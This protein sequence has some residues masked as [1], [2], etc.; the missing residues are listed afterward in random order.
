MCGGNDDREQTV[1]CIPI[2]NGT[3]GQK[4]IRIK[5]ISTKRKVASTT[6][7]RA[8]YTVQIPLSDYDALLEELKELKQRTLLLEDRMKIYRI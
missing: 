4:S 5:R 2:T 8:D 1:A 3:N 6:I 7:N